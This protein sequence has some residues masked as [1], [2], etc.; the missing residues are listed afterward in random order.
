MNEKVPEGWT[1]NPAF[2]YTFGG[3][4]A[5]DFNEML[6]IQ[7]GLAYDARGLLLSTNSDTATAD[8]G[9]QYISVQPSIRIFWLL[10]GLAFQLPMSGAIT[11]SIDNFNGVEHYEENRNID[12]P[13]IAGGMDLRAGLT[14]PV[15]KSESGELHV[16]VNGSFPMSQVLNGT[17][18][19]DSVAGAN[20]KPNLN[21]VF[22]GVG[23]GPLPTV[24]AGISYQFDLTQLK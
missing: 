9:V 5:L 16:L 20:P 14:I 1:S 3:L 11:A 19:F 24:E 21:R 8:I 6:G 12:N 13:D 2:A 17:T 4:I 10:V 22:S 23:R 7:L 15:Y 18:S